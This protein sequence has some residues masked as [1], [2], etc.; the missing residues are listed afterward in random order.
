MISSH[1]MRPR[2]HPLHAILLSFPVALF[3]SA[4]VSDITYLS[5]AEIQWSNISQW[6]ITGALIFGA[7][8]LI[9]AVFDL[10][11]RHKPALRDR[12]TIYFAL[13][14]AMWILGLVNAF[15]HSQDAWSSVG[16]VGLVLSIL[17][18]ALAF[19][20]AWVAHSTLGAG[21]QA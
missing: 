18:T 5:S 1:A 9:W 7:L 13:L 20:A 14:L 3:A 21:D 6:A 12:P 17:C 11:R 2:L 15:K 4:L 8:V 10:V 16:T 19:A